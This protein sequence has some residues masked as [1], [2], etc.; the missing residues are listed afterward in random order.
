MDGVPVPRPRSWEAFMDTERRGLQQHAQGKLGEALGHALPGE[1]QEELERI[2]LEDRRLSQRGLVRLKTGEEYYHKHIDE[3][4]REDFAARIAA[5]LETVEWLKERVERGK[6]DEDAPPLPH[7]ST[8]TLLE[9][10]LCEVR[11]TLSM[12]SWVNKGKR[13]GAGLLEIDPPHAARRLLWRMHPCAG[14]PTVLAV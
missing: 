4:S 3:L 13:K 8:R 6:R 10:R 14:H 1:N 9:R 2:A 11:R 12:R 5:E 7:A